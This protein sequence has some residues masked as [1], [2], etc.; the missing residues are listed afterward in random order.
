V[1]VESVIDNRSNDGIGQFEWALQFSRNSWK[2]NYKRW[3]QIIYC[4]Q[5]PKSSIEI[6]TFDVISVEDMDIRQSP[7]KESTRKG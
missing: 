4:S 2:Y 1:D 6:R 5:I 7:I 3:F